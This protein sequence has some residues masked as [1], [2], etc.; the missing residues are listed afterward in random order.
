VIVLTR[1]AAIRA[2]FFMMDLLS[3]GWNVASAR[4]R[5]ERHGHRNGLLRCNIQFTI[6]RARRDKKLNATLHAKC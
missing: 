5:G 3:L 1:S 6:P 4:M 2:I